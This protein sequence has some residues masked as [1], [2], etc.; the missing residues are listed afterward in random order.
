MPITSI[1]KAKSRVAT[2]LIPCAMRNNASFQT[3]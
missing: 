2:A 1:G 3:N